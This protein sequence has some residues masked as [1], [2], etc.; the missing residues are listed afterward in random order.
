VWRRLPIPALALLTQGCL[1]GTWHPSSPA[2]TWGPPTLV[3]A[4]I[5]AREDVIRAWAL[6]PGDPWAPYAKYTLLSA[7][8][9]A[10]VR[11]SLPDLETVPGV[12]RAREAAAR[13]AS[14][15]L[16]SDTLWIVDMRGATSVAFGAELSRATGAVSLVPTFNNW[17]APDELVPAEETLAALV[18]T[19]PVPAPEGHASTPVFLLDAWR[20]AYRDEEPGDDRYD[21]RYFL[22]RGDFPDAETLRLHGIRRVLYVVDGL[23]SSAVEEDDL[24]PVMLEWEQAGIELA[25]VD[26]QALLDPPPR[27]RWDAFWIDWRLHVVPRVTVLQT[28]GFFVRSPGGFG[29]VRASPSV[30]HGGWGFGWHGGGG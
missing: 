13:V 5:P 29:G 3:D 10:P 9:D 14:S 24:H 30:V 23:G 18:T 7:L 12:A 15:G 2:E 4:E 11:G 19:S 28:P 21:N 20:M 1:E 26:I 6:P 17:P 25:M 16:P 22:S 27:L 8:G